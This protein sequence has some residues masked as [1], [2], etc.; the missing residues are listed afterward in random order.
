MNINLEITTNKNT[1]LVEVKN[2]KN[3]NKQ[4]NHYVDVLKGIAIISVVFIHT[5]FHSGNAYYK[6]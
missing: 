6:Y 3:T 1:E 5:V 2:I 4:R